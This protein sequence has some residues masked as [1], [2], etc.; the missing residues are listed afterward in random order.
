[1]HQNDGAHISIKTHCVHH[2][3]PR[4]CTCLIMRAS[5][6]RYR[7][8][9]RSLVNGVDKNLGTVLI[10]PSCKLRQDLGD[11]LAM[12]SIPLLLLIT[13]K[14]S[15]TRESSGSEQSS[16]KH[17]PI[18]IHRWQSYLMDPIARTTNITPP[19]AQELFC[20]SGTI[21]RAFTFLDSF[22]FHS[23]RERVDYSAGEM[24]TR[25]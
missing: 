18:L 3:K 2:E 6:S 10:G 16:D 12:H 4:G 15:R 1:M 14:N 20:I 24:V 7:K 25:G 9:K 8:K 21:N 13:L 22:F 5:S 11:A 23:P 19:C 17:E